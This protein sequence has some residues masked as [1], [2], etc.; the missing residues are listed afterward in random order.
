MQRT[1]TKAFIIAAGL[2][3]VGIASRAAAEGYDYAISKKISFDGG[4]R[5]WNIWDFVCISAFVLAASLFVVGIM[6][7]NKD[8]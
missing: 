7:A 3:I 8:D 2:F 5:D 6:F 1:S 4:G